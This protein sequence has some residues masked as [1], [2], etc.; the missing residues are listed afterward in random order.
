MK[1][2]FVKVKSSWGHDINNTLLSQPIKSDSIVILF[3][4]GTYSCDKPLLH[5]AKKVSS[6]LGCD[7]LSLEYGYYKLDKSFNPEFINSIIEESLVAIKLV[8]SNNYNNIYFISKSLGTEIAGEISKK[9]GYN[10]IKNLFLTPIPN[11]ITHIENSKCIVVVGTNDQVISKEVV[12]KLGTNP[13]VD[14]KIIEG[15]VHSLEIEDDYIKSLD[16]LKEITGLYTSFI[17]NK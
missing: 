5:Y 10:K 6:L 13:L 9:L 17:S 8:L 7:V 2:S 3:P 1:K 15:A 12:F 11:S 14:L 16:I 4:G